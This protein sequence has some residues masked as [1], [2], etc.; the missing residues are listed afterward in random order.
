MNDGI[1]VFI[2]TIVSCT[3]SRRWSLVL[4]FLARDRRVVMMMSSIARRPERLQHFWF[5]FRLN[6]FLSCTTSTTST[7]WQETLLNLLMFAM[8]HGE[9]CGIANICT[10]R[11]D[12]ST[13]N[14]KKAQSNTNPLFADSGSKIICCLDRGRKC[15]VI[16]STAVRTASMS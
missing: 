1:F 8:L 9:I 5:K 10:G 11:R 2:F 16:E 13:C 15:H 6:N 4:K 12:S 7:L 3:R 14:T